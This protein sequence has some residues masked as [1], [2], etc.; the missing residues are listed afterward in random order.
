MTFIKEGG[1]VIT[2]FWAILQVAVYGVSGGGIFLTVLTFADPKSKSLPFC[3][4]VF[5]LFFFLFCFFDF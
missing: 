3:H 4:K 5:L 2:K 1:G